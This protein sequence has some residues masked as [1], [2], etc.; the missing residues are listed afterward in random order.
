MS[1]QLKIIVL[2]FSAFTL[3]SAT[4]TTEGLGNNDEL[5]AVKARKGVETSDLG[6][7]DLSPELLK[8]AQMVLEDA[9]TAKTDDE[10]ML[11]L[12]KELVD[13]AEKAC[14]VGLGGFVREFSRGCGY[15]FSKDNMAMV[16]SF[17]TR[18]R[19]EV[20]V[21]MFLAAGVMF[22]DSKLT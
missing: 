5:G 19:K 20:P 16:G 14:E 13:V 9:G 7:V 21:N 6:R 18:V 22:A 2:A 10:N 8:A 1:L 4:S 17:L 12:K 11:K 15:V 3:V